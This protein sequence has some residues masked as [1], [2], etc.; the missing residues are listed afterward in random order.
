MARASGVLL[1]IDRQAVLW[2]EAGTAVCRTLE[3]DP[4]AT[5]ASGT[6]LAAFPP[7]LAETALRSLRARGH[8]AAVIGRA[9]PGSGVRDADDRPIL[10]PER[11]EV[12]RVLSTLV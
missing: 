6:L 11:D 12:A 8:A 2:F 3:A 10:W 7:A 5:L 1:R 4:W 9:E